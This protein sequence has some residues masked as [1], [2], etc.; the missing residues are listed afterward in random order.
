M[1]DSHAALNL[2]P[3][4]SPHARNTQQ[5]A[6]SPQQPAQQT[7]PVPSLKALAVAAL[8]RNNPRNNDAT[9]PEGG[10]N[11]DSDREGDL[12]HVIRT[13]LLALAAS[14]GLPAPVVYSLDADDLTE[15]DGLHDET[16]RDWLRLQEWGRMM[17][18]GI[19]PPGYTKPVECSGCG[20]VLLWQ[21]CPDRVLACPWCFR[22]KAGN[23][24]PRPA[25]STY[26]RRY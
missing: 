19:A 2:L 6:Q 24:I 23:I 20:P 8:T 1:T 9:C 13:R 18:R 21:S 3:V 17:D 7:A 12:L 25:P 4:A 22:R 14:E 16:L 15:C 26:L 11:N 10:R 5:R